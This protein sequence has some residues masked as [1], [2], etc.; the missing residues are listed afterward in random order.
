[1]GDSIV[2]ESIRKMWFNEENELKYNLEKYSDYQKKKNEKTMDEFLQKISKYIRKPPKNKKEQEVWE[3][4]VEH[5]FKG[6]LKEDSIFNLKYISEEIRNSLVEIIKLFINKAKKFDKELSNESIFQAIRNIGIIVLLQVVLGSNMELTRSIFAYSMIYPYTDNFLDDPNISNE[7][8]NNFNNRLSTMLEGKE[9]KNK[10]SIEEKLYKLIKY[11]EDDYKRKE[12]PCVYESL[13]RIQNGQ[14]KS[15]NQQEK[16]PIP[17]KN[18]ILGISIEKGSASVLADG[19][20]IKGNLNIKEKEFCKTYGFLLQM[21]D[22]FQDL[23]SDKKNNHS[24]IMSQLAGRYYL[25]EII[26]K[27]INFLHDVFYNTE[28]LKDKNDLRRVMKSNCLALIL[29]YIAINKEYFTEDY[30]KKM[31]KYL[32]FSIFYIERMNKTLINRLKN[33]EV[34]V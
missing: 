30:I 33:M 2:C 8:K 6:F 29:C 5:I 22:D 26:D 1:M 15:V 11:I 20:L 12:Y 4:E 10:T 32:P 25:D 21:V 3:R 28:L 14:I 31:D 13:I 23:K 27:L 9:I 7:E 17:Y 24:T 16:Y 34:L 19:Y 18:D